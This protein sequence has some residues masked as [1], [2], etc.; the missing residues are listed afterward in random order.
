M[1]DQINRHENG[2]VFYRSEEN[3]IR[4]TNLIKKNTKSLTYVIWDA[5]E[6]HGHEYGRE[7]TI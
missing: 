2:P 1:L 6:H 3:V 4:Q 5:Y 7:K